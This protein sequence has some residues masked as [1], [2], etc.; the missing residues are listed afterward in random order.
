M[1]ISADT[2]MHAS[3]DVT[4]REIGLWA[5]GDTLILDSAALTIASWYQSP[6]GH[7]AV[8]AQFASTGSA[9]ADDLLEACEAEAGDA[10][11]GELFNAMG[12]LSAWVIEKMQDAQ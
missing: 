6:A 12:A 9:D 1:I 10:E 5:D 7:G 2:R 8:F 4:T 3:G 11:E